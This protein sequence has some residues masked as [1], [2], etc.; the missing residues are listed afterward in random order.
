MSNTNLTAEYNGDN[1]AKSIFHFDCFYQTYIFFLYLLLPNN[2]LLIGISLFV[3][4]KTFYIYLTNKN[5]N[6][7][8]EKIIYRCYKLRLLLDC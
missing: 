6:C 3:Y 4:H 2:T 1:K 7:I 5:K 8:F